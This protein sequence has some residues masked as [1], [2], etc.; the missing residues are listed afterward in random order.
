MSTDA[1]TTLSYSIIELQSNGKEVLLGMFDHFRNRSFLRYQAPGFPK[2]YLFMAFKKEEY[3]FKRS[4]K[5]IPI[6]SVPGAAN[7]I[8]S[9]TIYEIKVGE[10]GSVSLKARISPYGN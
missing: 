3:S 4:V 2:N 6:E 7:S 10:N 8:S 9:H 1:L 5:I